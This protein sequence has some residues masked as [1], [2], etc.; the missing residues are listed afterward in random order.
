MSNGDEHTLNGGP[1]SSGIGY[2]DNVYQSL[3][4][5]W[6]HAPGLADKDMG[7]VRLFDG[8]GN[9]IDVPADALA[10]E[11]DFLDWLDE[12]DLEPPSDVRWDEMEPGD[13]WWEDYDNFTL[14][15]FTFVAPVG[16][17][18]KEA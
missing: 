11:D 13:Y 4:D 6:D 2:A 5:K 12:Q 8:D 3:I 14:Y 7:E 17:G 1:V 16:Y 9:E 18:E 15:T 10:S